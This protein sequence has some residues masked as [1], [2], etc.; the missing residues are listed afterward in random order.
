GEKLV[1]MSA[2]AAAQAL[3]NKSQINQELKDELLKM[4]GE[5]QIRR[6]AT[7]TDQ[8]TWGALEEI[9]QKHN[10]RLKEIIRTYGWPGIELV[11]VEGAFAV[12]LLVQHQDLDVPFQK[13]CLLLLKE[14]VD[15]Q[16]AGF[17][18]YAYLLDRVY[19]N[20]NLSQVYGTQWIQK[21]G[22]TTLYPVEDFENLNQRRAQAGLCSIEE[23][24]KQYQNALHLNDCDFE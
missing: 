9:D 5:D 3:T 1:Q 22:K 18:D 19:K 13:E 21:N 15:R 8:S 7:L 4:E 6:M 11:G 16:D 24:R 17:R 10:P 12:W 23:Y 14:A 20:E 2:R